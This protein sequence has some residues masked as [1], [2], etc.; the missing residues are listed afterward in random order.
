MAEKVQ[1]L[2][3]NIHTYIFFPFQIILLHI[4]I[5]KHPF[6]LYLLTEYR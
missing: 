6:H 1:S 5:E 3:P 2:D 4:F